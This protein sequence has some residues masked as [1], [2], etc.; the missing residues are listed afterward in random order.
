MSRFWVSS[1]GIIIMVDRGRWRQHHHWSSRLVRMMNIMVDGDRGDMMV[2][3]R[4]V[5]VHH[6]VLDHRD[7]VESVTMNLVVFLVYRMVSPVVRHPVT[8][9]VC[10]GGDGHVVVS[11]R[12]RGGAVVD[13][14]GGRSPQGGEQ[15]Q[16][17]VGRNVVWRRKDVVTVKSGGLWKCISL[18][19]H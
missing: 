6:V 8:D 9:V 11:S 12:H 13:Q 5:M 3:S 2:Q 19:L 17:R 16:G 15:G 4:R 14:V 18:I 10:G 1:D 7:M